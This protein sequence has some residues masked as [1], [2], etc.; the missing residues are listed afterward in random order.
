MKQNST[1]RSFI[2]QFVGSTVILMTGSNL[3]YA[4]D[5]D[6]QRQ[7]GSLLTDEPSDLITWNLLRGYFKM[8]WVL[9]PPAKEWV[10][11]GGQKSVDDVTGDYLSNG[12]VLQIYAEKVSS[13]A[14]V[15]KF[16]ISRQ[17]KKNFRIL[18]YQIACNTSQSGVYKIFTPGLMRM[19]NYGI[20]LPYYFDTRSRAEIDHPV[21]WMQQTNGSNTLTLGLLD[22]IQRATLSGKTYLSKEG[23]EAPGLA[24]NYAAVSFER[25]FDTPDGVTEF[26]DGL[27]VNANAELSWFESLLQY[28]KEVDAFRSFRGGQEYSKWSLNP[29][30][31]TWYAHSSHIDEKVVLRDAALARELGVTTIEIDAGWNIPREVEYSIPEDGDYFFD[32]E[33]FPNAVQ[34]I[35]EIH[36]NGQKIVLRVAPLIMGKNA[37]ARKSMEDCLIRVKGEPTDYLDPRLKKVQDYLMVSWEYL[38]RHY[39][40]DGMFY[41]FLEITEE[42]DPV[43]ANA[44]ILY[45]DVRV[46]Y[47][48][49]MQALYRKVLS[50]ST[51]NMI[52]LRR[53]SANLNAK[54]FCT[55][56]WPQDVP[57]DYNGN[58]RDVVFM[59]TYGAGVLTHACSSS[60]TISESD[61]NVA[62]HMCSII[63][64]G[65]PF[66]SVLLNKSPLSHKQIIKIWLDF[67]HQH[68]EDLV[69]GE[70][71]PLLPTPPSAVLYTKGKK[72]VFIGF[73]EAVIGL[74]QVDQTDTV[75]IMNAFSCRTNTRLEGLTGDWELQVYDH[76]WKALEKKRLSVDSRGGINLNVCATTDCHVMSLRKQA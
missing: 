76:A 20:D 35:E 40:I 71:K 15:V 45:S 31:S 9:D 30:W 63:M 57:Q 32:K 67:Y 54:T 73:F 64:A 33:R 10:F 75:F 25:V 12:Y 59:K 58:R 23:G 49:L 2:G 41:D 42:P 29:A 65:V 5:L 13:Q 52:F 37:K 53:G 19:Q 6:N 60:W 22:Q 14:M 55:H 7:P 4:K 34:M 62:K 18:S 48:K 11:D 61:V 46:A 3:L 26:T 72:N 27:Y 66:F 50:I 1:R 39:R 69:L 38:F 8:N 56:M 24:N 47:T 44:D 16:T 74:V 68:K 28:S 43:A 36:G 51:D 70:M 17:D 21:L